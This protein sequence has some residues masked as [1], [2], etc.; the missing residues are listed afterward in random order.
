MVLLIVLGLLVWGVWALGSWA[1][2]QV[3]GLFDDGE[4]TEDSGEQNP[5]PGDGEDDADDADEGASDP[6]A[7]DP[8]DL[9]VSMDTDGSEGRT[10]LL[11]AANDGEAACLLDA[12][13]LGVVVHSGEDRIWSTHDCSPPS[14]RMLLLPSGDQTEVSRTW[15]GRRSAPG[16]EGE[17]GYAQSGTYRARATM[18]GRDEDA[19]EANAVFEV[20]G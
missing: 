8:A 9:S 20:A 17:Q 7:C 10:F 13:T 11:S 2:G 15:D 14:E 4:V 12:G 3:G 16:C 18:A 19:L 6:E 5:D 1:V